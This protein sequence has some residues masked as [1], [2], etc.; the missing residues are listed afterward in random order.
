MATQ[1]AISRRSA[2]PDIAEVV[3]ALLDALGERIL[4]VTAG[5]EDAELVLDWATGKQTPPPVVEQRLRAALAI[6]QL[7]AEAD[8]PV[9]IRS[10]WIG[11]N[12]D[13]GERAPALV[14]REQPDHV[15]AAARAFLAQ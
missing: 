14:L 1:R 2:E 7:L 5:V 3:R 11:M 9:T 6:V 10:W 12:P 4:T 8:D 15:L 13:L